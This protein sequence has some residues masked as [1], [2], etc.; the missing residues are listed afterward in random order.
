VNRRTVIP[1]SGSLIEVSLGT[2]DFGLSIPSFQ[3]RNRHSTLVIAHTGRTIIKINGE[4][5]LI[6][7]NDIFVTAQLNEWILRQYS[8]IQLFLLLM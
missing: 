2:L 7:F 8:K 5:I 3:S 1:S 4:R 6:I